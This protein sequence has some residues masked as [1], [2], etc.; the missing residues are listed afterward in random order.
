MFVA[1]E[2]DTALHRSGYAEEVAAYVMHTERWKEA[3]DLLRP[4]F[5]ATRDEPAVA[6]GWP[7]QHMP[8]AAVQTFLPLALFARLV[9]NAVAPKRHFRWVTSRPRRSESP[10]TRRYAR[11]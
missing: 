3:E 9:G 7:V 10:T 11:R 5:A 6:D 2:D 1:A 8:P 4:V